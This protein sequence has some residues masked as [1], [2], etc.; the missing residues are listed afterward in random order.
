VKLFS[1]LGCRTIRLPYDPTVTA[2]LIPDFER[3]AEAIRRGVQELFPQEHSLQ[4]YVLRELYRRLRAQL[5]AAARS[6]AA[7]PADKTAGP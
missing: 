1:E 6:A 7:E 5:K 4:I 3:T 2:R